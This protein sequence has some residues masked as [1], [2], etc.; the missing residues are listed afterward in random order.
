MFARVRLRKARFLRG[1]GSGTRSVAQRVDEPRV[2]AHRLVELAGRDGE[3]G[4][5]SSVPNRTGG[6]SR[7]SRCS[8]VASR[9]RGRRSARE[10]SNSW[11]SVASGKFYVPAVVGPDHAVAE[12]EGRDGEL[13]RHRRAALLG[14][15]PTSNTLRPLLNTFVDHGRRADLGQVVGADHPLVV[16]GDDLPRLVEALRRGTD[17]GSVSTTRLW[18]RI[19]ARWTCATARFSSFRGSGISASR[20]ARRA[21]PFRPAGGRTPAPGRPVGTPHLQVQAV[22]VELGRARI[23]R[24]GSVERVEV[25]R[26]R[27]V[28]LDVGRRDVDALHQGAS[29]RT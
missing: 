3:V 10:K 5:R 18:N 20:R 2:D 26:R 23:L 12:P 21:L 4:P 6:G 29:C 7:R 16:L 15:A 25:E 14:A 13:D 1:C 11:P 24:P 8:A 19:I 22:A 17:A 28:L 27:A 9:R